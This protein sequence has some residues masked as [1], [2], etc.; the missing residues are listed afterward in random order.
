MLGLQEWLV[1][2]NIVGR[3]KSWTCKPMEQPK[4]RGT[5]NRILKSQ[6]SMFSLFFI[7]FSLA[8]SNTEHQW[9]CFKK[10][11]YWTS[12]HSTLFLQSISDIYEI[13]R[14]INLPQQ[15]K[16]KV[17]SQWVWPLRPYE[18]ACSQSVRHAPSPFY[19]SQ[20]QVAMTEL[21]TVGVDQINHI[22]VHTYI[23]TLPFSNWA[24][25]TIQWLWRKNV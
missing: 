6:T 2:L 15:Q 11:F 18:S 9:S 3:F 10:V 12:W 21:S 24:W 23:H 19:E 16:L 25:K 13:C 8:G 20:W 5:R 14:E 1:S 22:S 7:Q 4:A 17:T